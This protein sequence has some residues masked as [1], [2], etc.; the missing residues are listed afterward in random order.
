MFNTGRLAVEFNN[1]GILPNTRLWK[2]KAYPNLYVREVYDKTRDMVKEEV[3]FYTD[4]KTRPLI[5]DQ[6]REAVRNR[7][8][9]LND[10][11]TLRELTTFIADPDTGKIEADLGC[12][13]D[14]VM[15]LAIANHIHEGCWEPLES[16]DDLYF[17][18]I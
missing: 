17:D 15:A 5:I 14:C 10:K 9:E 6:L 3:G 16:S 8:I 4:V 2:D 11:D 7:V 18:M 13:D 1:H 12:H